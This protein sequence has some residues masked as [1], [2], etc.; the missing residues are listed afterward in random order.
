MIAW[1]ID[2]L[3]QAAL[4]LLV[5]FVFQ[6]DGALGTVEVVFFSVSLF[7]IFWV[8][9]PIFEGLWKGRTPGKRAQRLRVVRT[10]GHPAGF[11]PI[12]VRNLVRI[13]DV[14]LLPFVAVICIVVTRRAQRLGDLAAGTMVVREQPAVAPQPLDLGGRRRPLLQ[15]F[16]IAH[17]SEREYDLIRSFLA[18]RDT[19]T[20]EA[21]AQLANQLAEA[22]LQRVG[23]WQGR[24]GLSDEEV[25]EAVA[26]SYRD[27]FAN[28]PPRRPS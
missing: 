17:L 10:D 28:G 2:T 14:F 13:V 11:A 25:L 8:Y 24:G 16:D 21:R 20:P 19:L 4:L 22:L 27:R 23:G 12:M 6:A 5:F 9:Y 7:V 3:I 1:L 26:T 15:G 18:R